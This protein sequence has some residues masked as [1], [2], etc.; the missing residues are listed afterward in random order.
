M[1]TYAQI[2]M[3]QEV[4]DCTPPATVSTPAPVSVPANQ[5]VASDIPPSPPTTFSARRRRR[6]F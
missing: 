5:T 6:K 2:L 3:F 4:K 1:M